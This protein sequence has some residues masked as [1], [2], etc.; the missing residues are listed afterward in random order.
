MDD[1]VEERILRLEQVVKEQAAL[2][3]TVADLIDYL[4][5]YIQQQ[6]AGESRAAWNMHRETST[7]L[8]DTARQHLDEVR[9]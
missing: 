3:M 2:L 4:T 1:S 5:R 9:E 6:T 7:D 8:R